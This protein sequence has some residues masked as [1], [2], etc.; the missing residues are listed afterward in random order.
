MPKYMYIGGYSPEA[1]A[2]MLEN[3]SGREAVVRKL[4]EDAGGRFELFYWCFGPDDWV[5]IG[6]LPDDVSA[7]AVS[8]AVSSSG[9][10]RNVR[11]H[12]LITS[13]EAEELLAKGKAIAGGYQRPGG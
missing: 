13:Q 9:R 4:A 7:A 5:F 12:R 1:W 6:D 2:G 3:P 8:V 10:L 11:T